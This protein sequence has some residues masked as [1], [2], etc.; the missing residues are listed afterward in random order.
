MRAV[1][2]CLLLSGAALAQNILNV[3][4]LPPRLREMESNWNEKPLECSVTPTKP[5]LNFSFRIQAGYTVRVPMNQFEGTGH[6]WIV[7]TRI[8]P[9][10]GDRKPVYL[11]ARTPLPEVPKTKVE[12]EMGGGYLLGEGKYDVRWMMI[13]DQ[14]RA[15]HKDWT[16]DARLTRAER[17]AR[18]AM[19][20]NTVDAFSLR[21]YPD[22]SRTRDDAPPLRIS[23]L[24][25]AAPLSPRRTRLRA[26]DQMLLIGSLSALLERLPTRSVRMVVF[27]LEQQKELYRRDNFTSDAIGQVS[28]SLNSLQLDL[29]DYKTLLNRQGHM[30]LLTDLVNRE[31]HAEQPS[32]AVVILGPV[33]RFEDKPPPGVLEKPAGTLPRFFFFQYKP[34]FRQQ[35]SL[36]DSLTLTVN[37]LKGKVLTIRTPAEFAKAIDQLEKRAMGN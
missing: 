9:Q 7:M 21:G 13:D 17:A 12:I 16:I 34:W 22:A 1:I 36:P 5:A 28:R 35:A 2:L 25:H 26:T 23:I 32:D 30:D 15:C 4:R 3:S 20:P 31:M 18:V 19:R 37:S 6:G 29:V 11:G 8:T 10:G 14:D 27:N 24:M 33:A